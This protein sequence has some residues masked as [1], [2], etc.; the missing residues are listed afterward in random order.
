MVRHQE[1][2][3]LR[4]TGRERSTKNIS[5]NFFECS[6]VQTYFSIFFPDQAYIREHCRLAK[7]FESFVLQDERFEVCNNVRVS[8]KS[9]CNQK[10]GSRQKSGKPFPSGR[11][12]LLPPEG[13]RRDQPEAPVHDQRLREAPHGSC[14]G[15]REICHQVLRLRSGGDN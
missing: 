9:R 11:P 3:G 15:Q 14:L 6:T 5:F 4:V 13:M 12:R 10:F 8:A 1:P 7:L 2:W